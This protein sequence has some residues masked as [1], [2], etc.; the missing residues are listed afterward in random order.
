[1][2]GQSTAQWYAM[3]GSAQPYPM[4]CLWYTMYGRPM[5]CPRYAMQC[6]M[7]AFNVRLTT[8][9]HGHDPM[10]GPGALARW[11]PSSSL[12][13][14]AGAWHGRVTRHMACMGPLGFP[15]RFM[16][17]R[18]MVYVLLMYGAS[19]LMPADLCVMGCSKQ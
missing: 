14:L 5:C 7:H 13:K 12:G 9:L 3:A 1:M 11:R 16:V 19:P 8:M 2:G 17:E 18:Y 10:Y 15:R 4:L 6:C